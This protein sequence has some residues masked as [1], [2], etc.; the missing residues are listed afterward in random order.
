M[1]HVHAKDLEARLASLRARHAA[2]TSSVREL[3]DAQLAKAAEA[4]AQAA[5]DAAKAAT[6]GT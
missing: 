6:S 4:E 1:A 3:V 2:A 5:A